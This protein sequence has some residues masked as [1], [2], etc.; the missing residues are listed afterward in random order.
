VTR[1]SRKSHDMTL[2]KL[3]TRR[4]PIAS[5]SRPGAL[6]KYRIRTLG[7][8]RIEIKIQLFKPF[9]QSR[10]QNAELMKK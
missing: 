6:R 5:Q 10:I 3:K 2:L 4:V 8:E 7:R 1:E 9:M